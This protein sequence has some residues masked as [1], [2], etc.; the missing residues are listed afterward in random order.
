[1]LDFVEPAG[2]PEG[3]AFADDGRHGSIIPKPGRV[4][5]RN[6]MSN[7][8][9]TTVRSVQSVLRADQQ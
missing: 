1:M 7:L 6:D 2:G 4:R 8:V 5:S 9:K 3:G